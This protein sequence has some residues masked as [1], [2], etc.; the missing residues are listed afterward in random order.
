MKARAFFYVAAGIF[1][2]AL[3]Y[4]LGARNATAQAGGQVVALESGASAVVGGGTGIHAVTSAGDFYELEGASLQWVYVNNVFSSS[5]STVGDSW[6]S[7]KARYR[8]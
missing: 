8:K 5:T 6:G 2:L 3:S 7:V 1:L 4:H